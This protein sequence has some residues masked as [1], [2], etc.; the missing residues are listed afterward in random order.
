LFAIRQIN[1]FIDEIQLL[2]EVVMIGA[3]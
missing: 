1:T 3:I 2:E